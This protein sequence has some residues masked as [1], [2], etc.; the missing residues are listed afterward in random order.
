MA[1]F[2]TTASSEFEAEMIRERLAEAGI[3]VLIEGT[4]ASPRA[5]AGGKRDIYVEDEVL[6][7]AQEALREAQEGG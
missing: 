2:L 5:F 1:R 4:G 6:E 3:A 7:R